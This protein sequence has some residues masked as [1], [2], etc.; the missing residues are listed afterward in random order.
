M[1]I[2]YVAI[3][4][5]S[6]TLFVLLVYRLVLAAKESRIGYEIGTC[7][8]IGNREVQ[9]DYFTVAENENG[10]LAVLA[11]GMGKE[12]GGKIASRTV[13][14]VFQEL[15]EE[16]NMLDHPSYF[17]QK[18]FQTANRE[19]L[20]LFEEGRGGAAASAVMIQD[21]ILYYAIVGNVKV[22]VYRKNELIP[23]GTGHTIDVLAK[24]KYY[25]GV[26]SREDALAML[27]EKRIYNYLGRDGFKEIEIYD[28][29]V[30][31][32]T[33][34]IVVVMSD[35]IYENVEWKRIEDF[36][37]YKKTSEKIALEL[38]EDINH[39]DGEKDNASVVI[40][41]VGEQT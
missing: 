37:S 33:G 3:Y 16:Y 38:I 24:D 14:H 13:I 22:A 41:K 12:I 1:N 23:L 27:H 19:I 15:F 2:A 9:E 39:K 29:P 28:E 21:H 32:Q 36:L 5:L 40:I 30:H 34:D 10:L 11:D 26:L 25:Q 35:G 31:L 8:T 17:F 6:G 4:C 20:K 18:A 7:K